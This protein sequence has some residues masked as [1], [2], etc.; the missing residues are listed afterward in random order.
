MLPIIEFQTHPAY[1]EFCTTFT[2]EQKIYMVR[3]YRDMLLVQS[4]FSQLVDS[5]VDK[6]EW[7]V[8]RQELRDF[9]NTYDPSDLTPIFPQK[10]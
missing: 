5:P 1:N 7:A 4:D 2:E 3:E 6:E 10:P 9:M 8:Y